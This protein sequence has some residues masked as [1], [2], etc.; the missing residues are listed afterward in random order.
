MTAA[1]WMGDH[2]V[3]IWEGDYLGT[4]KVTARAS[5]HATLNTRARRAGLRQAVA[6]GEMTPARQDRNEVL[7]GHWDRA[8]RA[9]AA[10]ERVLKE[11]R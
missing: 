6:R 1:H 10:H 9:F 5:A 3:L 8:D 7:K 11:G 4:S 2:W